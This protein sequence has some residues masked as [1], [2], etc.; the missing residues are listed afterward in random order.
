M[1]MIHYVYIHI[2]H[3]IVLYCI[4]VALETSSV[5]TSSSQDEC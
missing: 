3:A 4:L 2:E 5:K 1:D